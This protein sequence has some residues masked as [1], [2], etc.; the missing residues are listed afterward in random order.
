VLS[1]RNE[2]EAAS[3][4]KFDGFED[5][6]QGAEH[7]VS[8]ARG[9]KRKPGWSGW[10]LEPIPETPVLVNEQIIGRTRSGRL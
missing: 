8:L 7:E 4:D 5:A 3:A 1:T 6:E 2:E 9:I 10:V